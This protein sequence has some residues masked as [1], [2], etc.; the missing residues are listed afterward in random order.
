M[1]DVQTLERYKVYKGPDKDKPVEWEDEPPPD[2]S[3]RGTSV[4]PEERPKLLPFR[5]G[6]WTQRSWIVDTLEL[7]FYDAGRLF[8]ADVTLV[9]IRQADRWIQVVLSWEIGR[10]SANSYRANVEGKIVTMT[11]GYVLLPAE[12]LNAIL[13]A[14]RAVLAPKP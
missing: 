3:K 10:A 12:R 9:D 1:A 2:L 5:I 14:V 13:D 4:V 6:A 7:G 8:T 11:Y